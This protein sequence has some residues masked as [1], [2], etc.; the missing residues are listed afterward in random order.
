MQKIFLKNCIDI[1]RYYY[2]IYNTYTIDSVLCKDVD[3][4]SV[5]PVRRDICLHTLYATETDKNI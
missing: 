4:F 3:R 5:L 2:L 1:D